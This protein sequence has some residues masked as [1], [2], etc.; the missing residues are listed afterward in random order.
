MIDL[1]EQKIEAC[2]GRLSHL[3]E[4]RRELAA[5]A[6][7]ADIDL[8]SAPKLTSVNREI[9]KETQRLTDLHAAKAAAA[10]RLEAEQ[11]RLDALSEADRRKVALAA[12]KKLLSAVATA[13]K[14]LDDAAVALAAAHEAKNSFARAWPPRSG[15]D[16]IFTAWNALPACIG[17][18]LQR[19]SHS[20]PALMTEDQSHWLAYFPSAERIGL[21]ESTNIGQ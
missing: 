19:F 17:Y 16:V 3:E 12:H 13:E 11:R 1:I 6:V 7:D 2:K 4:Q 14:A 15:H 9:I 20:K 8:V 21:A 10:A 18:K 5:D